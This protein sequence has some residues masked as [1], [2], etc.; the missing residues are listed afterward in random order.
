MRKSI[1]KETNNIYFQRARNGYLDQ[2][3]IKWVPF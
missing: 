3:K 2:T 1:Y